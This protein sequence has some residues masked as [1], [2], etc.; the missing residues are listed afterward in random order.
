MKIPLAL[1][2]IDIKEVLFKLDST[3]LTK[4]LKQFDVT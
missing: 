1:H 4:I 3:C 2:L